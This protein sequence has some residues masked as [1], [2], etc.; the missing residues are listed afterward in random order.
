VVLE[1]Q[2]LQVNGTIVREVFS[3]GLCQVG[4]S[5]ANPTEST[6]LRKSGETSKDVLCIYYYLSLFDRVFFDLN[7]IP[8][9]GGQMQFSSWR[10]LSTL[11]GSK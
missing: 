11:R 8:T 5:I 4:L 1:N 2:I 10:S 7:I 9:D 6:N 3:V